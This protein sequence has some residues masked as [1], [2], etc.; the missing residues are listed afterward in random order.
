M[1]AEVNREMQ[2]RGARFELQVTRA[3]GHAVELTRAAAL[4]GA[5][6]VVAAGGDGTV[7]EVAN[8][9]LRAREAD[10]SSRTALGLLPVG[11]GNDFVKVVRGTASRPQAWETLMTGEVRSFDAGYAE[12]PGGSEY[13]VNAAGTGIDVEVVRKLGTNR[14]RG[15]A[16]PYIVA[17]LRALGS[18]RPLPIRMVADATSSD[19][20][21]MTVAIANGRC[22]GGAFRICPE[23]RPDDGLFDVCAVDD[24]ALLRS[25]GTAAAILRGRHAHRRGVRMGRA[26][27]V[28][29]RVQADAR[30]F[31]Q[32][33][34]EL[35]ESAAGT[36]TLTIR[37][38]ALPVV[39]A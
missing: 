16:L 29:L 5:D 18:Y 31:F 20:R 17:L 14:G 38:G 10:A 22:I 6:V 15:G 4:G 24:M 27:R 11:T 26:Q 13:F 30:L 3:P 28:D 25:L 21:I 37:P 9:L 32:L 36:L 35:R 8:G 34:G 12:W 1:P 19:H 2:A 7:H 23:A 33:D 39:T